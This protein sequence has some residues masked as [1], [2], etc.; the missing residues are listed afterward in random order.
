M[1]NAG[2]A[3]ARRPSTRGAEEKLVVRVV[4][5]DWAEDRLSALRDLER[6]ARDAGTTGLMPFQLPFGQPA[7][8]P[9]TSGA[10]SR[11]ALTFRSPR[12]FIRHYFSR[13]WLR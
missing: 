8:L 2:C 12:P 3:I 10:G 9:L 11:E 7:I 13:P 6:G 4:V 5:I 1:L